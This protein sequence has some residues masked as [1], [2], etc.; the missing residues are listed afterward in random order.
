[1]VEVILLITLFALL[2]G[3]IIVDKQYEKTLEE[4]IKIREEGMTAITRLNSHLVD[5]LQRQESRHEET[6]WFDLEDTLKELLLNA[7]TQTDEK[8][9][10]RVIETVRKKQQIP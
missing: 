2:L 6:K 8:A 5:M 9:I 4:G 1:M 3:A 7:N 10:R